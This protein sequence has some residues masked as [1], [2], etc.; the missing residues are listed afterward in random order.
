MDKSMYTVYILECSDGSY[1]TGSTTDLA[2][3]L[4]EHETGADE[5]AYTFNWPSGRLFGKAACP[6]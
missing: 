6:N 1:Y 3:R 2:K 4:T 5:K